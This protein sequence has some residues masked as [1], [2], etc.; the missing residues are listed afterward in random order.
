M[1]KPDFGL[2]N[3]VRRFARLGSKKS[4]W[5]HSFELADGTV[6]NGPNSLYDLRGGLS[7]FPISN[8]LGK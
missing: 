6:I 7:Q 4:G 3:Y 8:D 5:W 1:A 2:F